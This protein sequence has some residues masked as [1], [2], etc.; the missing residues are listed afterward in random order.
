MID[1]DTLAHAVGEEEDSLRQL[2][3]WLKYEGL[4]IIG[5]GTV[6]WLPYKMVMMALV[7]WQ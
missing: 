5:A 7:G 1:Q 3:Y 2:H 6:V 4:T